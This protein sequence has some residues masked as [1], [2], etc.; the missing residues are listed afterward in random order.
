VRIS[1]LMAVHNGGTDLSRTLDSLSAAL[2]PD[3]EVVV[4]DDGSDDSTPHILASRDDLPLVVVRQER[5][6]QTRALNRGLE[7]VRGA[8]VARLD[9]GDICHPERLLRQAAALDGN[10]GLL[11]LGCRVRRLDHQGRLL[12]VSEVVRDPQAIARGLLRINLFQHSSLM[13]RLDSL[14][15]VGG[16]R[17]FFRFSQ[18]LD[19]TLRLTE[20]GPLGNLDEA[21]SDWVLDPGSVTF[22][23]RR[24]QAAFAGIARDCAR[25]RRRGDADPVEAGRVDPPSFPP[26]EDAPRLAAYHLEVA[27]S[28]LMGDQ[29]AAAR[30]E[31][32]LARA[33]GLPCPQIFVP[34]A[35]SWTPAPVRD[36]LRKIRV[37]WITR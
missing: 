31:L 22:R 23:H 28:L 3:S 10:P 2:P 25:A 35:L 7:V 17:P 16:Y 14:E 18:D 29:A 36:A 5:A 20:Q 24:S 33:Q 8:Y 26:E 9:A 27:R 13:L 37:R 4:V 19:L 15:R 11:G 12:G 6:G 34:R 1:V 32:A 21:L 30:R